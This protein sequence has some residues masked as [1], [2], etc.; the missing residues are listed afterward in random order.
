MEV[1]NQEKFVPLKV[2]YVP[3]LDSVLAYYVFGTEEKYTKMY[4]NVITLAQKIVG[5][6]P[7]AE[8]D[9]IEINTDLVK[10][11]LNFEKKGIRDNYEGYLKHLN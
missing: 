2:S 3:P 8:G 4:S 6:V 10:N 7:L 11:Q 1:K 9:D 5:N